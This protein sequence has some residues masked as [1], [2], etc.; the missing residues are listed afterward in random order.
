MLP[1]FAAYDHAN[2]TG[3]GAVFLAD[4]SLLSQSAP[5]V[6]QGFENGDFV[7][8]EALRKFNQI[9]DDQALEHVNRAEKVAGGLVGIMRTDTA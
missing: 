1:W 3:W 9:P 8:K 4:M 5:E 2:Y 6:H 7:S